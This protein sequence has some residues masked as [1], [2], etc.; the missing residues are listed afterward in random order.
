[1]S[2]LVF[3]A[4]SSLDIPILMQCSSSLWFYFLIFEA[5]SHE[6]FSTNNILPFFYLWMSPVFNKDNNTF[7]QLHFRVETTVSSSVLSQPFLC[8]SIRTCIGLCL[9][10]LS[11]PW[12]LDSI[13]KLILR[14]GLSFPQHRGC[15]KGPLCNILYTVVFGLGV[16]K[17]S[18]FRTT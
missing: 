16:H 9:H 7:C 18:T 6:V 8:I 15:F 17:L 1:M 2:S 5:L 11:L 14:M 13:S 12:P 4:D 3:P 10:S